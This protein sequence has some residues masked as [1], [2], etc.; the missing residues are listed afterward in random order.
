[1][2]KEPKNT[3]QIVKGIF[4]LGFGFIGIVFMLGGAA[5]LIHQM[6]FWLD[7]GYWTP[8][9]ALD[10]LLYESPNDPWL[11]YPSSSIGVHKILGSIP[12]SGTCMAVGGIFLF[13]RQVI[14]S[15][16]DSYPDY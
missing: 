16:P 8:F 3:S 13:I 9:S 12:F 7:K 4:S 2:E 10:A 5:Y 1:M 6:Y 15:D 14:V 11:L